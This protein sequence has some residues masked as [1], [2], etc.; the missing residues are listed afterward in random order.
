MDI[1]EPLVTECHLSC[2]SDCAASE[3]E[4][5]AFASYLMNVPDG[6]VWNLHIWILLDKIEHHRLG[7]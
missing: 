1:V 7:K 4:P 6:S 2:S 3:P 5:M